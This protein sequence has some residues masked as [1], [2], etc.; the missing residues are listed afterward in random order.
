MDS[1]IATL[2]NSALFKGFAPGQLKTLLARFNAPL[3]RYTAQAV[4]AFEDDQCTW[5]GI[6]I[7]GSVKI[8]RILASGK[9]MTIET[10][11]R[12]ASFGEA[13]IFADDNRYPATIQ[14]LEDSQVF[15]LSRKDI[16]TLCHESVL[17]LGNFNRLLSNRLL[18]LN[19]KVKSL[20]FTTI[21][22]RVVNYLLDEY[23][24]Q[25][26]PNLLI[27]M[28]RHE[29]ANFLGIPRPSLSRELAHLQADGL[30]AYQRNLIQLLDLARL[31]KC[32]F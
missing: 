3:R 28:A 30:I 21:R 16:I 7:S 25:K 32:L 12:G 19:R 11:G 9:T 2:E 23:Q 4:V 18:M 24:R 1:L 26:T 14:S 5:L 6:V 13:L 8:E 10:L 29:L 17:F 20:S 31:E 27:P 22:Q 15:C